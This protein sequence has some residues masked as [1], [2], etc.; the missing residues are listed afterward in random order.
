[1]SKSLSAPTSKAKASKDHRRIFAEDPDWILD[2]VP[3][4]SD[5]CLQTI[6]KNFKGMFLI[7]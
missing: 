5:K 3:R 7:L 4:L 2:L 1:M 6:V